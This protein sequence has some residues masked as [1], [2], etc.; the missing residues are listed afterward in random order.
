MHAARPQ[1]R[2]GVI[3]C[4]LRQL[5]DT[6]RGQIGRADLRPHSPLLARGFLNIDIRSQTDEA[7]S[8][9]G[10]FAAR[11]SGEEPG[12]YHE[13]KTRGSLSFWHG[14]AHPVA[15]A[16][17]TPVQLVQTPSRGSSPVLRQAQGEATG[18]TCT[19][20]LNTQATSPIPPVKLPGRPDCAIICRG[21]IG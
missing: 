4:F 12:D 15:L 18:L 11:G 1:L 9:C 16:S 19:S 10:L 6:V 21:R 3:A 14:Y 2:H 13:Q 7:R 5:S 8:I 20:R 17:L